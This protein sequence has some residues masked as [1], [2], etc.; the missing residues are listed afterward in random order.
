MP[1]HVQNR[2]RLEGDKEAVKAVLAHIA[3]EKARIDFNTITPMPECL[4]DYAPDMRIVDAVKNAR[5]V[6]VHSN[7]LIG[8]L[9]ASNRAE[10]PSSFEDPYEQVA[11]ER[12][13]ANFDECGHIYWYDWCPENWGTK[14]NAYGSPN[15]R[16]TEDTIFFETAWSNISKLIRKLSIM[17]PA[18][19]FHY[20]WADE[21]TGSNTGRAKAKDGELWKNIPENGSREAYELRFE[22]SPDDREYY[23][24]VDGEYVYDED[25]E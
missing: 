13:C 12:G 25:E 20:A 10:T 4:A 14:W 17:F 5:N 19:T 21:D 2:L 22:L 23:T 24:L 15:N 11:F 16:D 6:P 7:P 8:A 3:G 1:N 18:V 9:E